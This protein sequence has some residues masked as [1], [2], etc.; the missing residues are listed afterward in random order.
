MT[1]AQLVP[2][3]GVFLPAFSVLIA[4][5]VDAVDTFCGVVHPLTLEDPLLPLSRL[6]DRH[7][8]VLQQLQTEAFLQVLFPV[9]FEVVAVSRHIRPVALG[10]RIGNA[11]SL[12]VGEGALIGP[13]RVDA[14]ATHQ[15]VVVPAADGDTA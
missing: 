6:Q 12:P 13:Q 14:D 3:D 11:T 9:A 8:L 2:V 1:D 15:G 5:D 7:H 4:G 10:L